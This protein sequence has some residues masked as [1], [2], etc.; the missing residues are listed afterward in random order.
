MGREKTPGNVF[1][2]GQRKLQG[3]FWLVKKVWNG[4]ETLGKKPGFLKISGCG[5]LQKIHLFC[6]NGKDVLSR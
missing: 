4:L 1:L 2:P 6:S 3:I 5:S